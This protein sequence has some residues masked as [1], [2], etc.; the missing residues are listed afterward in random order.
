MRNLAILYRDMGDMDT[1]VEWAERA[2]SA[3]PENDLEEMR[4]QRN[5]AAQLYEQM[6]WLEQAIVQFEQLR[7]GAPDDINTLNNL[8][9]LYMATENWNGAIEVLQTLVSLEPDN[10]QHP[11]TL[12]QIMQQLGQPENALTFANQALALA[13]DDQKAAISQLIAT[14]DTGS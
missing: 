10:F 13:P 3:T 6:G 9:R 5:L 11:L 8:S 1:A 4:N 2:I 14:L 7:A 12:A